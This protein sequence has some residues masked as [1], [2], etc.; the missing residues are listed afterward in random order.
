MN[1]V[2]EKFKDFA[3]TEEQASQVRGGHDYCQI[4]QNCFANA[5][6]AAANSGLSRGDRRILEDNLI[7]A[8]NDNFAD[9][10]WAQLQG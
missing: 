8:C 10:C 9:G 5:S 6:Y 4:I 3:L 1:N 2:F 7:I